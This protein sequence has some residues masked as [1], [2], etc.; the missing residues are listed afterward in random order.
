M[1]G[2]RRASLTSLFPEPQDRRGSWGQQEKEAVHNGKLNLWWRA[3]QRAEPALP[4]VREWQKMLGRVEVEIGKEGLKFEKGAF[5]YY[6]GVS[7]LTAP[8]S[9]HQSPVS[10]LR[11]MNPG[12]QQLE[13]TETTTNCPD[14]TVRGLTDLQLIK[15]T[16]LQYRNALIASK[17][18]NS[19]QSPDT[20]ESKI[21]PSSQTKLLN[22]K[23]A[24][25]G[26]SRSKL[27]LLEEESQ[28]TGV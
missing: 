17:I 22:D 21:I 6:Y 14:S 13:S 25:P 27:N 1:R 24:T 18:Q 20:V 23:N 12:D 11:R 28:S 16:R 9:V 8:S 10:T 19:Q 4:L 7:A 26:K 3:V 15:V 5:T 2:G